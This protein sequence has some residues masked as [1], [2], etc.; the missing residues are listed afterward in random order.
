MKVLVIPSW[1]PYP[2]MHLAG[3]FF[4]EQASALAEQGVADVTILN[5]GQNEFQL[6]IR[7]PLQSLGKLL[8]L[9][10]AKHAYKQVSDNLHEIYCPHLSWTSRVCKGNIDALVNKVRLAEK[11]DLIHAHVSFPAGYLAWKLSRKLNIPFVITEHS[12]PFPF[13]EFVSSKGISPLIADPLKAA[14][15]VVA[16]SSYIQ[17]ELYKQTGVTSLVIPNLVDT[18]FYKPQTANVTNNRYR[19]FALSSFTEAKGALDL[20]LAVKLMRDAGLDFCLYWGGSGYLK[21]RLH[22][23]ICQHQ[24]S[25]YIVFLGQINHC[26]ALYQYQHCDCFVMPSHVESFSVVLIEALACGKPVIATDCGGPKDIVKEFCGSLIPIAKPQVMA[27]ALTEM[28]KHLKEYSQQQI[29]NYCV[30]NYS[31]AVVCERIN[32]VYLS[33]LNQA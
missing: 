30:S 14:S 33:S 4:Y 25:Q 19:L 22:K 26:E 2:A 8:K 5:W 18:G 17:T 28:Q 23:Y 12:G 10:T 13:P 29:R 3:K 11:P 7:R 24:L 27:A 6:A 20:I 21:S 32:E 16:V 9:S 31:P 15:K 1:Y